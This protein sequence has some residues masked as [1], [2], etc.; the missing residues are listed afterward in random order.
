MALARSKQNVQD[1]IT[2]QWV[3]LTGRKLNLGQDDWLIGP[4]GG[5]DGIGE[6]F[7]TELAIQE[8]LEL[9]QRDNSKGLIQDLESVLGA[10]SNKNK[11]AKEVIDFYENTSEYDFSIK[12]QWNPLFKT[13]GKLLNLIFS[14]RIKQL[15]IP[16][17]NTE[18]ADG[19]VS[20]IYH[21]LDPNTNELKRTIWLRKF[22]KSGDV[23]YS[24]VYGICTN[25]K[26]L[27]CVKAVFPLPN[28]NATVILQPRVGKSGALILESK[29]SKFGEGGFYFLLQDSKG[30]KWAKYVKTFTDKLVVSVVN[31]RILAKQTL[32]IWGIKVLEFQYE[33]EKHT[34]QPKGKCLAIV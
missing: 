31:G 2:Q 30:R 28:G 20:N 11:L 27:P 24:G 33:I 9:D 23:V 17:Q 1:W 25:P 10:H 32:E 12:V 3:I 7:I 19:I 18:T 5:T 16:I 21:L 4:F 15:N 6:S 26:G 13:F 14:K 22:K 34:E 29:G 8:N